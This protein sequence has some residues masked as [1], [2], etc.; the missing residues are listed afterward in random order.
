MKF[1]SMETSFK[2]RSFTLIELLIVIAIIS[3]L[4]SLLLPALGRAKMT[5]NAIKCVGNLKQCGSSMLQYAT[6]YNNF[7]PAGEMGGSGVN[8]GRIA[9]RKLIDYSGQK[10]TLT[11]GLVYVS[12]NNSIFKCPITKNGSDDRNYSVNCTLIPKISSGTESWPNNIYG[13]YPSLSSL[14]KRLIYMSDA[15]SGAGLNMNAWYENS[16]PTPMCYRHGKGLGG[17]LLR[18]TE[19]DTG[20]YMDGNS[21]NVLWTDGSVSQNRENMKLSSVYGSWFY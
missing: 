8:E 1:R 16:T 12:D 19:A 3:I 7:F 6:D 13:R 5:A 9:L 2:K 20:S 10:Y 15:C 18:H 17:G 21:V 4:A 14:K 11:A